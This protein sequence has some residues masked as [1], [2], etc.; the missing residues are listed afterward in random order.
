MD[1]IV[2]S[3]G[4]PERWLPVV[5]YEGLYEV[6][7]LGRV[8]SLPHMVQIGQKRPYLAPGRILKSPPNREYH[9]HGLYKDGKARQRTVHSLVA[10]AFIGPCPPGQE[11]RHGPGGRY[12]NRPVNLSY[13]TRGENMADMVRDGTRRTGTQ[14]RSAKLTDEAVLECRARA[15]AGEAPKGLAREFGT[16]HTTMYKAVNSLT[17]RH[18]PAM[19]PRR[20]PSAAA[21]IAAD[22]EGLMRIGELDTG[23]KV[24]P[25]EVIA[26]QYGVGVSTASNAV[27]LLRKRGLVVGRGWSRSFVLH[28]PCGTGW[29]MAS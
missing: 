17:W 27:A 4:E 5:D 16:S 8:R 10:E 23:S 28:M 11:V 26:A 13:G 12:D 1:Q 3:P 9:V 20:P 22:L 24:P 25:L 21:R 18:L 29:P 7:D 15:A 19:L 14:F 2:T 6:S